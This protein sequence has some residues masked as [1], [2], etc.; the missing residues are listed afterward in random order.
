MNFQQFTQVGIEQAT[1]L[2]TMQLN[3]LRA[4]RNTLPAA[5]KLGVTDADLRAFLDGRATVA[6]SEAL[7]VVP[8]N[9]AQE[10]RGVLGRDGSLGLIIGLLLRR[11]RRGAW[12]VTAHGS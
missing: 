10:L 3:D 11:E 6:M 4:G 1:G 9:A 12:R 8:I 2:T 5:R 7:S